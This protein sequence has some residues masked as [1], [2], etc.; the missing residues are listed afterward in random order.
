[1]VCE[2]PRHP[3]PA[4]QDPR[5]DISYTRILRSLILKRRMEMR[6]LV[7]V[8]AAIALLWLPL[9][10]LAAHEGEEG[11]ELVT[12]Q[13]MNEA[14]GGE[15]AEHVE[16]SDEVIDKDFDAINEAVAGSAPMVTV[17]AGALALAVAAIAFISLSRNRA[18]GKN[19]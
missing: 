17:K 2:V 15:E 4:E 16:L 6:A 1:V 13:T 5:T 18:K 11:V 10:T 9:S 7:L 12:S 3:K 14:A 19:E 8:I